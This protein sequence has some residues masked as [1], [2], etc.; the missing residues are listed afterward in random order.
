MNSPPDPDKFKADGQKDVLI[1]TGRSPLDCHR[2]CKIPGR[3]RETKES[4]HC[5][6]FRLITAILPVKSRPQKCLISGVDG[7][8]RPPICPLILLCTSTLGHF[9]SDDRSYLV[10]YLHT[11]QESDKKRVRYPYHRLDAND[12]VSAQ[13]VGQSGTKLPSSL[14]LATSSTPRI[15]NPLPSLI[16]ANRA[17]LSAQ[18]SGRLRPN[19]LKNTVNHACL[20]DVKR[21][22]NHQ[23]SD[24]RLIFDL[25]TG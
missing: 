5:L 16:V 6:V 4:C 19:P 9:P 22:A 21:W 23:F 10:W 24:D 8:R 13:W 17:L 3:L 2:L 14:P 25:A 18:V 11:D 15:S 20:S 7:N 1:V 12:P